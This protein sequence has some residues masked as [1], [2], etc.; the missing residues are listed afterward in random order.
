MCKWR[1]AMSGAIDTIVTISGASGAGKTTLATALARLYG[2]GVVPTI[3]TRPRRA[4]ESRSAYEFI[5]QRALEQRDA[6]GDILWTVLVGEHS[7]AVSRTAFYQAA[8][9]TGGLAMIVVTPEGHAQARQHW[10]TQVGH[11]VQL[12]LEHPGN[13]ELARRLDERGDSDQVIGRRMQEARQ[14]EFEIQKYLYRQTVP[15]GSVAAMVQVASKLID[16]LTP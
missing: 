11:F 4:G 8:G 1:C 13:I 10:R 3:T 2:G 9:E 6:Q 12:H 5:S 14:I 16:A 15:A 7:Y